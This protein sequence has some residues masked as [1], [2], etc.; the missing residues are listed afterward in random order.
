MIRKKN[1]RKHIDNS[2]ACEYF[3]QVVLHFYANQYIF[4]IY[5]KYIFFLKQGIEL[6]NLFFKNKS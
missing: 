2:H 6:K 3:R 5:L 1:I 4:K